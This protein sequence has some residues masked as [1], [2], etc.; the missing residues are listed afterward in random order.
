MSTYLATWT[1]LARP[2]HPFQAADDHA[3]RHLSRGWSGLAGVW[4]KD[5]GRYL[6]V[7][8]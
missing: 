2:P 3:A 8:R 4:R 5:G 6:P 7:P 1:D